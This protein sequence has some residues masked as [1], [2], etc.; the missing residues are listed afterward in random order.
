MRYVL[1][2]S[3]MREM[4]LRTIEDFG[5]SSPILMEVAGARCADFIKQI[6]RAHV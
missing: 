5:I 4:D 2:P 3:Q 1:S 6:G